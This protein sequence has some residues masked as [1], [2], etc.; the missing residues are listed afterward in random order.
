MDQSRSRRQRLLSSS[1]GSGR[2]LCKVPTREYFLVSSG[3]DKGNTLHAG[4]KLVGGGGRGGEELTL[5]HSMYIWSSLV[6]RLISQAYLPGLSPRLISQAYLPG[7]SPRL[8]SQ[9]YLP[10]L[11]PR[12]I[13]QAYLPGLSPRLISQA[14]L[15][16]LSPRLISQA[17]LPGL[18][19]RLISQAYLPGLYCDKSLGDQPG[20]EATFGGVQSKPLHF[21][22]FK[23]FESTATILPSFSTGAEATRK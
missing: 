16:G 11:S 10:G 8:I 6:P 14:Y 22:T 15:P 18:S 4:I 9:A 2:L 19:P 1:T 13:S 23:Y 17:Y 21:V 3:G 7:L 12:L 5:F 20:N